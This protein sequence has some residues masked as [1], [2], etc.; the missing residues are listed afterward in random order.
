[1]MQIGVYGLPNTAITCSASINLP[2]LTKASSNSA[3]HCSSAGASEFNKTGFLTELL[4]IFGFGNKRPYRLNC[5]GITG[6]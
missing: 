6:S 4:G 2:A 5:F 3:K 1:M